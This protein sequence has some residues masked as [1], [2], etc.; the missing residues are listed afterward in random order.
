MN[1][2]QQLYT[3][4]P[5]QSMI[6]YS[7][8]LERLANAFD[9]RVEKISIKEQLVS[10]NSTLNNPLVHQTKDLAQLDLVL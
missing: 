5:Y 10:Q 2:L 9:L 7:G 8:L 4:I 1:E 6:V 3:L